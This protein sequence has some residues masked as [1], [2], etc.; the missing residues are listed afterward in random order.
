MFGLEKD[1]FATTIIIFIPY[2]HLVFM[3]SLSVHSYK[4]FA[5]SLCWLFQ[6][7]EY[8]CRHVIC[9]I[10]T[11]KWIDLGYLYRVK[12]IDKIF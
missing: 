9:P 1:Q 7:H 3:I 5:F 2:I 8:S 4:V 10:L 11:V 12:E 6:V